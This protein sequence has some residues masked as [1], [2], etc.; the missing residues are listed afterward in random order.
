MI[1]GSAVRK[2]DQT[3]LPLLVDRWSPR[4]MNGE[5]LTLGELSRLLEAARWAPSS[6]N[7][8]PWRCLY[9][10]RSGPHW[11]AYLEF[12]VPGNRLWAQHGGALAV[13]ISQRHTVDGSPFPT[14]SYDTGAAWLSFAL[15]GWV[16]GLVVHGMRG[17]DA[18]S[19][20]RVLGVPESYS[21][22]AM[23]A[24]GKPGDPAALPE[25]LRAR[26]APSSRRPVTESAREGL[27]DF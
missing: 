13:F 5:S 16:D 23:A 1:K 25:K 11:T 21:V 27:F 17:F 26:E 2:P 10:L 9:A 7:F 19:V 4:A 22:D 20:R 14:H 15:Q 3:I 6:M 18:E 8:Q 12:L 24:V